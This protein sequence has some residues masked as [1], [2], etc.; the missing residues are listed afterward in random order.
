MSDS[1]I[2]DNYFSDYDAY[3]ETDIAQISENGITLSN[4]KIISFADCV[5]N[6]AL[7]NDT[8]GQPIVGE[9]EVSDLSFTFYSS[10]RAVMIKFPE[11]PCHDGVFAA[12]V[13]QRFYSLQKQL[14]AFGF[15][16][17]DLS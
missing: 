1:A 15:Y 2:K 9:R 3:P 7:Y 12:S 5:K 13:Q 16:T 11:M 6:Y 17:C 10:P 4:G 14:E 8:K